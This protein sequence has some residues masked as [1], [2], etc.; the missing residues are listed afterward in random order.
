MAASYTYGLAAA[1]VAAELAGVDDANIGA[2]TEPV[3]TSDIDNWINDGS[4]KLNLVLDKSGI[5]A[6]A[7]LDADTHQA[8]AAAVK[9]YAVMRTM[10]VL[11]ATGPAF[12]LARDNWAS[13]YAEYSNRPQQLGDAY[14]DGLSVAID[15][16]DSFNNTARKDVIDSDVP[17]DEWL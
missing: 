15:S 3:S 13:V 11:G 12:E 16:L 10:L 5:T 4:A 17:V 6:S 2:N 7:S 9:D 1:D 14:E 8:L